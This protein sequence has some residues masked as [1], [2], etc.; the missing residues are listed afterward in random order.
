[1]GICEGTR[2]IDGGGIDVWIGAAQIPKAD[3]VAVSVDLEKR[4]AEIKILL[5]CSPGEER[6]VLDFLNGESM[7]AS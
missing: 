6:Q 3:A 5:G 4:D 2:S 1:M 7:R